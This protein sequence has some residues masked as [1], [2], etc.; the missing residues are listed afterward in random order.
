[1]V[2]LIEYRKKTGIELGC[3]AT[4]LETLFCRSGNASHS[5]YCNAYFDEHRE[6]IGFRDG[7]RGIGSGVLMD[8]LWSKYRGPKDILSRN[9][10]APVDNA[11]KDSLDE[12]FVIA[13]MYTGFMI[14][15]G[16]FF[17]SCTGI[18]AG[19]NRSGDLADPSQAIPRGTIAATL[20]TSITYLVGVLLIGASV[21]ELFIRD[22]FGQSAYGKLVIAQ[23]A[24][25]HPTVI[26]IGCFLSTTGA[27]LQSLTGAPRL[28]Q[29]ISKDGVLPILKPFEVS[30]KRGEP[31]RAILLTL[32]ICEVGILIAALESITALITQF[33]LMCYLSVNA[34][35]ALQ[36]LLRSPGWRPSFRYYHWSLSLLGGVLCLVVMF[37]SKWQFAIIAIIIGILVYKYIEYRGAEQEW[38]DGL[39]GLGLSGATY[40]LLNLEGRIPHTKNWRPQLLVLAGSDIPRGGRRT[41]G[42][43]NFCSQLKAG[44]GLTVLASVIPGYFTESKDEAA[45]LRQQLKDMRDRLKIKGFVEV[46]V[47]K[48]TIDGISCMY[49]FPSSSPSIF[50]P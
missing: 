44:K 39:R 10:S 14:L 16:V 28:F 46:L 24:V 43:L 31:L 30:T 29:A 3:N 12:N 41:E 50:H 36:S 13:E 48:T 1:M 42:L 9:D 23:L 22:K 26:L 6:D 38:G 2:N 17:P 35:C 40:A 49:A 25:P 5:A 32:A 7:I 34:A 47:C 37:V 45:K 11:A 33:F 18:M 20:T 4:E 15:I 21:D 19:S 27:G 8:N